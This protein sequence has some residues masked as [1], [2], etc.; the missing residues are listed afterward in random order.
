MLRHPVQSFYHETYSFAGRVGKLRKVRYR[1]PLDK[2]KAVADAWLA[3]SFG[4]KPLIAD[5]NDAMSALN[6]LKQQGGTGRDRKVI[7]ALGHFTEV[8]K[9]DQTGLACVSGDPVNPLDIT[10]FYKVDWTVRYKASLKS[11]LED[12]TTVGEQFGVGVFDI[13]PAV[14]EAIPWSFFI[15]YF[16]N[17]GE[18]IDSCRLWAADFG[19]CFR[20][21]RNAG[22]SNVINAR[23]N[24]NATSWGPSY[25]SGKGTY[26]LCVYVNRAPSSIPYPSFR[27]QMPGLDS[28]KWL[29]IAALTEQ[30][31]KAGG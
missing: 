29:N 11:R 1:N 20:S 22:T 19:W 13:V 25:L 3:Y 17:V 7:S 26:S 5:A 14:W 9:A 24:T 23:L 2:A 27:F 6:R 4:V 21:V 10:W 30:V 8:G 28:M 16:A 15:D 12:L 31:R 18:M